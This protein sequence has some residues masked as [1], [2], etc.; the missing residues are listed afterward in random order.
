[1]RKRAMDEFQKKAILNKDTKKIR[2][3]NADFDAL[4]F[5]EALDRIIA[6]A[7]K[8]QTPAPYI[9]TPNVDHVLRLA[10]H[11]ELQTIYEEAALTL[12]DGMP[13]V[14]A[15]KIGG[16]HLPERVTGADLLPAL[17]QKAAHVGMTVFLFGGPPG[18]ADLAKNKFLKR[19]KDLKIHTYCPP[20]G[21]EQSPLEN[22][23]ALKAI[24]QLQPDL[25]F[26]GLGSPKQEIWIHENRKKLKVGICLG[27]GAAIEFAAETLARAPRWMQKSGTEWVYRLAMDPKRLA[28]RYWGN[29]AFVNIMVQQVKKRISSK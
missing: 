22:Q 25:L 27:V 18:T 5:Q 21:F 15:A 20:Y 28:K 16:D 26:V 6:I 13:V 14:W 4:G 29:I 17:V 2:V 23:R 9:V 24:N 19:Y 7:K 3:G 1:M 10:K 12:A 11:P 8:R